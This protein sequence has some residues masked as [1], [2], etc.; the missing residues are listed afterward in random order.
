MV[1]TAKAKKEATPG[2]I[3]NKVSRV[4]WEDHGDTVSEQIK[5]VG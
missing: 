1:K 5:I 2:V 4:S 3:E